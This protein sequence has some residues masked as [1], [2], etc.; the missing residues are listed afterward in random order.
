MAGHRRRRLLELP[1]PSKP[2][3]KMTD[4]ERVAYLTAVR[5]ALRDDEVRRGKRKPKTMRETE[6]FLQALGEREA[7]RPDG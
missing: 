4:A 7:P 2:V 3:A 1:E 5:R 6:I